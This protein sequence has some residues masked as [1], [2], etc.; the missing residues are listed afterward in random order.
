MR[1]ATCLILSFVSFV[2]LTS[3]AKLQA[4]TASSLQSYAAA[5]QKI[6]EY[7]PFQLAQ[8]SSYISS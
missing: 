1:T 7:T 6:G 2:C 3:A 4:T 8:I 5:E